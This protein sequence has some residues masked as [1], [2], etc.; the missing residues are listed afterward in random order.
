VMPEINSLT[1]RGYK[2]QDLATQCR[3]EEIAYLIWNGELP[4]QSQL[5]AFNAA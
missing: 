2:V 3:I 5:D 1:Y 4:T